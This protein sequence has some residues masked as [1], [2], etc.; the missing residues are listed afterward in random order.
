[1]SREGHRHLIG[2]MKIAHG[3]FFSKLKGINFYAFGCAFLC[4]SFSFSMV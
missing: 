1:M 4:T 2:A 3:A